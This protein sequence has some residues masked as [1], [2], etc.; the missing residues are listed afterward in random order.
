MFSGVPVHSLPHFMPHISLCPE[1]YPF[2][3]CLVCSTYCPDNERLEEENLMGWGWK[4]L[5]P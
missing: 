1:P 2:P 3:V 5:H 4:C